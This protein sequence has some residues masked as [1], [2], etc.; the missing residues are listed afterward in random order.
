MDPM[1]AFGRKS[2]AVENNAYTGPDDAVTNQ[3]YHPDGYPR[4]TAYRPTR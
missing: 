1:T 2:S 3:A 4:L